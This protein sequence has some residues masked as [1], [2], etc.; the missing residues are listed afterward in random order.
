MFSKL[1]RWLDTRRRDRALRTYAI[2]DALWQATLDGL[3]FL[4]HF[5]PADLQRLREMTSLF[6]AQKE[7]STAHDLE[8]TEQITVAIAVQACLPVLNL[9][10]ELYRGWVGVIV[11]PGEFVI[12]KTVED[13]DGVVHEVEHDA[14][15]EAW[16]GGPVILSWEDAQMTDS[17]DAYNV[18]IHEFAHKIDMVTGEADGHPPLFRKLHAPLDSAHWADVFDHAYDQFCAKVDAV[19]DRRWAR[20]E[21]ESLIDPYATDHPSEFF[22]VCSEA[23]FVKPR[24]FEAEYPELY[25]LLAR[26]YRQ[27]PARTGALGD[28]SI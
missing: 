17:S 8:L 23:L 15:G 28:A 2:D 12:R 27:D 1:T 3:P 10:L 9:G 6:I 19:P 16:E 26:Y 20:F 7:F 21:R 22:A 18:V 14:S 13:E 5:A 11:Y 24:E 4:S 25:G